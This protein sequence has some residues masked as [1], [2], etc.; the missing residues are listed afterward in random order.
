VNLALSCRWILVLAEQAGLVA[1]EQQ[2]AESTAHL[3]AARDEAL[4]AATVRVDFEEL[5]AA[6]AGVI[7]R[8]ADELGLKATEAQ[9]TAATCW[10]KRWPEARRCSTPHDC[11]RPAVSAAPTP[12]RSPTP[13]EARPP[14][15]YRPPP[16]TKYSASPSDDCSAPQTAR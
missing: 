13:R 7:R 8:L 1:D 15:G 5:R 12:T 11:V 2:R 4:A 10:P 9:L 3:I 6:P 14:P 16:S